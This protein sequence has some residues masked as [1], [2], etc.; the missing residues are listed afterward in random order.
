MKS[1][2]KIMKSRP[3]IA[4]EEIHRYMNFE[5]LLDSKSKYVSLRRRSSIIKNTAVGLVTIAIIVTT[6]VYL[7]QTKQNL[8]TSQKELST[9][10]PVTP[11]PSI[12]VTDSIT[13]GQSE[14]RAEKK[15]N[16]NAPVPVVKERTTEKKTSKKNETSKSIIAPR[17]DSEHENVEL[18]YIQAEPLN[19]YPHLYEYFRSSLKYPED[20]IADSV[21][22]VVT[23]NFTINK[24]GKPEHIKVENSPAPVFDNEAIRVIKNMPD[25]R[26]A[27]YNGK[28]VPSKMSLPLTF[29]L[30]KVSVKQ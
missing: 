7:N 24:E 13:S 27:R 19:G 1:K 2:I 30:K 26:P 8:Q 29:E 3:E 20:A 9:N 10:E 17:Q 5:K 22:A 11:E 15:E 21:Q 18:A 14:T 12:A 4:D 28:P 16:G 25:W 6:V 23:V